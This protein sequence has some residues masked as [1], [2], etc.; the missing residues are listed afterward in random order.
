MSAVHPPLHNSDHGHGPHDHGH[1]GHHHGAPTGWRRWLFATNHKDIG[2]MYLLFSFTML[3]IGGL[4]A[5][6]IRAELFEP[7]LQIINPELFNQLTT[8][9]GLIMVF[10]AIMPA[11]VGFAYWMLP[12]GELSPARGSRCMNSFMASLRLMSRLHQR[13]SPPH[14]PRSPPRSV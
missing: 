10:G 8:M 13:P 14:V 11:F 12:Q 7:G 1:D 3:M 5:M 2:T 9:H 4:L 6:L